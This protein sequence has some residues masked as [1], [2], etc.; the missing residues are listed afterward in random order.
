MIL[1]LMN[2]LK[3]RV[4]Q[5]VKMWYTSLQSMSMHKRLLMFSRLLQNSKSTTKRPNPLD[6]E[7]SSFRSIT[8]RPDQSGSHRGYLYLDFMRYTPPFL[9]KNTSER[10]HPVSIADSEVGAVDTGNT[11]GITHASGIYHTEMMSDF[12]VNF[13]CLRYEARPSKTHKPSICRY[14]EGWG[15][16]ICGGL[17]GLSLG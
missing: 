10:V 12:A 7:M 3:I 17:R 13:L 11:G 16:A 14:W 15:Y 4:L 2:S 1:I 8:T 6:E 9:C 5:P